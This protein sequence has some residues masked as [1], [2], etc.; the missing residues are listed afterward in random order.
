MDRWQTVMLAYN[1]SQARLFVDGEQRATRD[2]MANQ[3]HVAGKNF[4][5]GFARSA[6]PGAPKFHFNGEIRDAFI[7]DNVEAGFLFQ[8]L[9]PP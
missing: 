9:Q 1:G 3:S 6:G 5:I 2:Y 4:R 7:Y 8:N